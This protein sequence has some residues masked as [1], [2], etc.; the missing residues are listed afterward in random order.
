MANGTDLDSGI[1]NGGRLNQIAESKLK[2]VDPKIKGAP[3]LEASG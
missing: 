1:V 2:L 3:Q